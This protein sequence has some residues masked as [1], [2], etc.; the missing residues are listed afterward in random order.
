MAPSQIPSQ[1]VV[2]DLL[3]TLRVG[4]TGSAVSQIHACLLHLRYS[5]SQQPDANSE[6]LP[7]EEL[8]NSV[9]GTQTRQVLIKIQTKLQQDL[10]SGPT[11][12]WDR[13]T[14]AAVF[15]QLAKMGISLD[16]PPFFFVAGRIA[17]LGGSPA[18]KNRVLVFD[19]DLGSDV[20]VAATTTDPD[21]YFFASFARPAISRPNER[22]PSLAIR[23]MDTRGKT[24]LF[25]TPLENLAFNATSLTIF[26]TNLSQRALDAPGGDEFSQIVSAM[27]DV[28]PPLKQEP[29][30]PGPKLE[31][32]AVKRD[33]GKRIAKLRD[34]NK[35][36]DLQYLKF[37]PSFTVDPGAVSKLVLSYRLADLALSELKIAAP[38]EL[39]YALLAT[40]AHQSFAAHSDANIG[41]ADLDLATPIKPLLFQLAL[42]SD[43]ALQAK[44]DQA[45]VKGIVSQAAMDRINPGKI[46]ET[47][48]IPARDWLIREPTLEDSTW[49]RIWEFLTSGNATAFVDLLRVDDVHGDLLG[50]VLR[51]AAALQPNGPQGPQSSAVETAASG[52]GRAGPADEGTAEEPRTNLVH[53]IT[54]KH[55]TSRRAVAAT[56]QLALRKHI[57]A[58][59]GKEIGDEEVSL[60][61]DLVAK[62]LEKQFPT[63]A[64]TSRLREFVN[65]STAGFRAK[66]LTPERQT[67]A[68]EAPAP[69]VLG[70]GKATLDASALLAF[71]DKHPDFDLAKDSLH[72]VNKDDLDETLFSDLRI[73]QRV[74]RLAPTFSQCKSLLDMEVQ[75]A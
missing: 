48:R 21:G 45:I 38:A 70:R 7:A 61:A 47:I 14:A 24:N 9:F 11:G 1:R 44:L 68:P 40:D 54:S 34:D 46:F 74:F 49:T 4:T 41:L 3:Q 53:T 63:S 72:L 30:N 32:L 57:A 18:S 5:Q 56:T 31:I 59:L 19:R 16:C 39:F 35:T 37:L 26:H 8:A 2:R 29:S 55:F 17:F 60:S 36:S 20:Q 51:L 6:L 50:F 66:S 71:T 27:D 28:L 65:T 75:S 62:N 43:S 13:E 69:T 52:K 67:P 42:Q 58:E 10:P 33:L 64:F 25:D 22:P 15:N 12:I 73:A 23:V